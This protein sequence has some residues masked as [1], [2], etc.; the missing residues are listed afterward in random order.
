MRNVGH[1]TPVTT[2]NLLVTCAIPPIT[3]QTKGLWPCRFRQQDLV[4]I[5]KHL[6]LAIREVVDIFDYAPRVRNTN[7]LC[8]L[9]RVR[10]T[11]SYT[12]PT[13]TLTALAL[14]HSLDGSSFFGYSHNSQK[15]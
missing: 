13:S 3:A 14:Q 11:T 7:R 2:V 1:V 8:A 5:E 9:I 10:C 12:E 15:L 4:A 6:V